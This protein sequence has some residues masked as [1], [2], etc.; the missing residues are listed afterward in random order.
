[1]VE[2]PVEDDG[3]YVVAVAAADA[4]GN[5]RRVERSFSISGAGCSLSEIEPSSGA[6]VAG[7]TLTIRGRSSG[8]ATVSVRVP[9]TGADPVE[10]REYPAQLA[11]GTFVAGDVP[12]PVIGDNALEVACTDEAGGMASVDLVIHR[13]VDGDGPAVEILAPGDGTLVGERSIS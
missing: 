1:M 5:E 7:E 8:A 10:H 12:L 2:I 6:V 3:G 4:A 11:D 9:V 13:L